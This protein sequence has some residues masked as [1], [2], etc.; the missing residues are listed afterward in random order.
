MRTC[1]DCAEE[2]M[3][4]ILFCK[5]CGRC[6]LLPDPEK[7]QPLT[8][9]QTEHDRT[10][11]DIAVYDGSSEIKTRPLR[12]RRQETEPSVILG[13]IFVVNLL[14]IILISGIVIK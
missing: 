5:R 3:N 12:L 13:W 14:I 4:E 1:P 2:N 8:A 9:T 7:P 11:E 10:H 6:L